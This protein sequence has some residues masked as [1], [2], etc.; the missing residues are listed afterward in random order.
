ML[1]K[2]SKQRKDMQA[3]SD[4]SESDSLSLTAADAAW[5]RR[6]QVLHATYSYG[7]VHSYLG[8]NR[9]RYLFYA[10]SAGVPPG[11]HKQAGAFAKKT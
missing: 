2:M 4:E 11:K 9:R 3:R 5:D 8:A 1:T 6:H 10:G 7:T